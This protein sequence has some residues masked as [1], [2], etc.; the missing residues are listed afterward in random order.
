MLSSTV[1]T[2]VSFIKQ[3][4][5]E[6]EDAAYIDGANTWHIIVHIV[7]PLIRP[8]LFTVFLINFIINCTELLYPLVFA[9]SVDTKALSTD[10]TELAAPGLMYTKPWDMMSSMSVLMIV[11]VLHIILFGL[12]MIIAGLTPGAVK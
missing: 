1:L 4:P 9:R 2:L 7:L 6:I 3:V 10:L 12:H 5:A 8:A 11:P